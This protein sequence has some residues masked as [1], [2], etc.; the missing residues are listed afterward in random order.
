MP[1]QPNPMSHICPLCSW[2]WG[3]LLGVCFEIQTAKPQVTVVILGPL[4]TL[5]VI[6][7]HKR[8]NG[9]G[10]LKLLITLYAHFISL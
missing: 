8:I 7:L 3:D 5:S 1:V 4:L 9:P 2:P 6:M 10:N